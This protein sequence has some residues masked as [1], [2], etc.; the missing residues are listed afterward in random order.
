MQ[1]AS[2]SHQDSLAS[3]EDVNEMD[4]MK[5]PAKCQS[6]HFFMLIHV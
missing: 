2:H 4:L 5:V 3:Q 6:I 1:Q